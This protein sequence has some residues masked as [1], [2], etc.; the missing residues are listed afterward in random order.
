MKKIRS[1]ALKPRNPLVAA[2][3]FRQAGAHARSGTSRQAAASR[4]RKEIEALEKRP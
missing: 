2:A 3:R 4:L 1:V